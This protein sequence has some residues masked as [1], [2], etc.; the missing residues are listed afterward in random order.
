M[1]FAVALVMQ[2]LIAVPEPVRKELDTIC[3][4][5]QLAPVMPEIAEEIKSRTPTWPPNLLPGDFNG[6]RETDVAVLLECNG[7]SQLVA[8]LSTPNGFSKEILEKPQP[9]DPRQFLYLIRQEY[10]HHAIGVEYEAIGGHAWVWRDG[11][12]RSVVQ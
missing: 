7:S 9:Y 2:S 6:D 8:F 11:K 4:G 3:A 5:W 10:E 1:I 12:W